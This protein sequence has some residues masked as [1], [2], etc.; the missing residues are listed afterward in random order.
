MA[1]SDFGSDLSAV[2][3]LTRDLA[4]ASGSLSVAQRVARSWLQPSGGLWYDP[5]RGGDLLRAQNA[6]V[7]PARLAPRLSAQALR[8][9]C[10]DDCAVVVNFIEQTKTLEIQ[11]RLTLTDGTDLTFS[12]TH[13]GLTAQLLIG[14]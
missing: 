11:A 12:V 13:D 2:T 9:E 7:Y 10:V 4:E 6:P 3:G 14:T 5:S 8:D 1:E